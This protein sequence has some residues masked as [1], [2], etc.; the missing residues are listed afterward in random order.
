MAQNKVQVALNYREKY[1]DERWNKLDI[2]EKEELMNFWENNGMYKL[3]EINDDEYQ[4]YIDWVIE[5]RLNEKEE[6]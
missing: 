2:L 6:K 1:L 3:Y 4:E 5:F